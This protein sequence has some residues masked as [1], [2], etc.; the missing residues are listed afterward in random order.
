MR[1]R[2]AVTALACKAEIRAAYAMLVHLVIF[3]FGEQERPSSPLLA[4]QMLE[5]SPPLAAPYSRTESGCGR[6]RCRASPRRN[7]SSEE[8][9]VKQNSDFV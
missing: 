6:G 4:A 3:A 5:C 1:A 2:A 7:V 8:I 9:A